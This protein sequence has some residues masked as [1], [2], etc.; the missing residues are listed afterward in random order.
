[1]ADKQEIITKLLDGA[2]P[3]EIAR[4]LN[5]T[6]AYVSKV[7]KEFQTS[8]PPPR[9]PPAPPQPEIP[10]PLTY[11]QEAT[12]EFNPGVDAPVPAAAVDDALAEVVDV[13]TQTDITL[14]IGREIERLSEQDMESIYYGVVDMGNPPSEVGPAYGISPE[15]AVHVI[16]IIN[17]R[18][19]IHAESN[20]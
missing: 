3:S 4:E 18:K 16:G 9:D 6:P 11:A 13:E 19:E 17:T 7:K 8:A 12:G 14:R 15:A 1:V 5:V 10:Q 20:R 2:K